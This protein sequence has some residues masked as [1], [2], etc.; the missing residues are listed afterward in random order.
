M[1]PKTTTCGW[2]RYYFS[3]FCFLKLSGCC[4]FLSSGFCSALLL[5]SLLLPPPPL[6]AFTSPPVAPQPQTSTKWACTTLGE[7]SQP[8]VLYLWTC[9]CQRREAL[10]CVTLLFPPFLVLVLTSISPHTHTSTPHHTRKQ[11]TLASSPW[12]LACAASCCPPPHP[13]ALHALTHTLCC[14]ST[15]TGRGI[16]LFFRYPDFTPSTSPCLPLLPGPPPP[17]RGHRLLL[18]RQH[19]RRRRH[20]QEQ[21]HQ[22][23]E[24]GGLPAGT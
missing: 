22:Q 18:H 3:C 8:F 2:P 19:Q 6:P 21:Q 1:D 23:Q 17:P 10:A 7:M 16:F 11:P 24:E 9:W 4:V 12:I 13:P 14:T 20:D 15:R 5:L